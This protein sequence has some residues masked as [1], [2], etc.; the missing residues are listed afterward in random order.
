MPSQRILKLCS[1]LANKIYFELR[2]K[3]KKLTNV[4]KLGGITVKMLLTV[5]KLNLILV[6]K[7]VTSSFQI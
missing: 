6:M 1:L 7:I 2:P 4:R 5:A 3:K